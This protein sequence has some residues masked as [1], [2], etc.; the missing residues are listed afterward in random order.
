MS[1]LGPLIFSKSH[2]NV[3]NGEVLAPWW[4][5]DAVGSS[6]DPLIAN[7]TGSTQQLLRTTLIQHH[8]PD[9][10]NTHTHTNRASSITGLCKP[11]Q[12]HPCRNVHFILI[13][14]LARFLSYHGALPTSAFSPCT[15]RFS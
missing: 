9:N 3:I 11:N 10:H 6:E 2:K 7:Q 15:I 5:K 8:L 14:L 13:K 1:S 12:H 4:V